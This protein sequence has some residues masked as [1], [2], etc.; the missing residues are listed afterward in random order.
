M[1]GA[2]EAIGKPLSK[3]PSIRHN[4]TN[5]CFCCGSTGVQR[6]LEI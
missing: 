1:N 4:H 5:T 3:D 2:D 6:C